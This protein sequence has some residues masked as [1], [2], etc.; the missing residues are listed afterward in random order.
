[1]L[2]ELVQFY[3]YA[4]TGAE[5]GVQDVNKAALLGGKASTRNAANYVYYVASKL[6]MIPLPKAL[7]VLSRLNSIDIYGN[8]TEFPILPVPR[9]PEREFLAIPD[10]STNKLGATTVPDV[11]NVTIST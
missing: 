2:H 9:P 5:T 8:C 1:M 10:N 3:V 4:M 6:G 11:Q 7:V